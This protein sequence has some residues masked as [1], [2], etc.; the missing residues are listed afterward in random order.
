VGSGSIPFIRR[1]VFRCSTLSMMTKQSI[2]H[3]SLLQCAVLCREFVWDHRHAVD[4]CSETIV[5]GIDCAELCRQMSVLVSHKTPR[6]LS[7][8]SLCV[9]ACDDLLRQLSFCSDLSVQQLTDSCLQVRRHCQSLVE[10]TA[11]P[12]QFVLAK[13]PTVC[14]GITLPISVYR[15]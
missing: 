9:R 11:T 10:Q 5:L 15:A 4:L 3:D 12:D 14:Y 7:T 6:S 2:I 8:A 13:S 1:G